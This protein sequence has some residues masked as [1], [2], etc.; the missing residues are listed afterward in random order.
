MFNGSMEIE[1]DDDDY[2]DLGDYDLDKYGEE[3]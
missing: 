2:E 1:F 3:E